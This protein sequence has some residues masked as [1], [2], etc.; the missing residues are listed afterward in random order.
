M[1]RFPATEYV[2]MIK[3]AG[4]FGM[5]AG[6]LPNVLTGGVIGG[7]LAMAGNFH[8]ARTGIRD[9]AA[10]NELSPE[11]A[12]ALLEEAQ[13]GGT[14]VGAW[15]RTIPG[16]IGGAI[17]GGLI[18][19]HFGGTPDAALGAGIGGAAGGAALSYPAGVAA[20]RSSARDV[21]GRAER[22]RAIAG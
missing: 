10:Q 7:P 18:G 22:M 1:S 3:T 20:G 5:A 12:Q 6:T 13:T 19:D 15:G 21:L 2:E 11:A 4:P 17:A 14:G 16:V 9:V 8:G